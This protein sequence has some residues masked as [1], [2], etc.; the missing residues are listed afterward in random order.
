MQT[1]PDQ[2]AQCANQL[3]LEHAAYKEAVR[4]GAP[5]WI[6]VAAWGSVVGIAMINA[7]MSM[8]QAVCMTLIV[9]AGTAQLSA[10]PLLV[11]HAPV[12]VIFFTALVVN[13]RFVIFSAIL[14]P[15]FAH[16]PWRTRAAM[17]YISGDVSVALF[18]QK[19]P[20]LVFVHG[21]FA[22]LKGLVYPNWLSWQIGSLL[23]IVLGSQVPV[24][25]GLSFAGTLALLCLMLPMILNH[26]GVVGVLVA[27]AI[28]VWA[29]DM[30]F[31]L[32]LLVAVLAGMST[33]MLLEEA[34]SRVAHKGQR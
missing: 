12:W 6:G 24:S 32:G 3:R 29:H 10:L 20:S 4:A 17:G 23:G 13:L 22:Y 9:F 19:F 30:P 11:A 7:G 2:A 31:K 33:A 15:H 16:L 1:E 27:S 26:A 25:W 28:A 21:K 14:A 5:T 8:P 18:I 34:K